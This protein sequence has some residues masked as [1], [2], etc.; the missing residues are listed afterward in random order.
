MTMAASPVLGGAYRANRYEPRFG[1][2][3][4]EIAIQ[5]DHAKDV[6]SLFAILKYRVIGS[7]WVTGWSGWNDALD[8]RTA[9]RHLVRKAV[10]VT[11][12][13]T[14]IVDPELV[15]FAEEK[16]LAKESK[17]LHAKIITW[18][19]ESTSD[20]YGFSA[21]DKGRLLR[22]VLNLNGKTE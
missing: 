13:W 8:K 21:Y 7:S 9:N 16:V 18:L 17:A 11:H 12:G 14:H 1:L 6:E 22:S 5:G 2:H 4:S 15:M 3:L 20:T 10:Y 19:S